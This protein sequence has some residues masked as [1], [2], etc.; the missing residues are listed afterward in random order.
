ME[1]DK[2]SALGQKWT[3][4]KH[5]EE[6]LKK[7]IKELYLHPVIAQVLV[8]RGFQSVQEIRDFLYPQFP[9]LHPAYGKS[10]RS[11]P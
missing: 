3:Y 7:I 4:P 2:L 10:C 8:S 11:S 6:F 5:N 9:S 1:K